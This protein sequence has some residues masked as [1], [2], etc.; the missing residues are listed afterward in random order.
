MT[1]P[2]TPPLGVR[3]TVYRTLK[4]SLTSACP[5]AYNNADNCRTAWSG[6]EIVNWRLV[7]PI[8]LLLC[9]GLSG[10]CVTSPLTARRTK[11]MSEHLLFNPEWTGLSLNEV[12]R[13]D[14]P[15][16]PAFANGGEQVEYRETIIDRQGDFGVSR[17]RLYRRF[18]SVRQGHRER[19]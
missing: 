1:K 10:C 18:D 17:D 5:V 13:G 19:P 8:A 9:V 3:I 16:T 4:L 12:P 7:V 14:W 11:V 15:S 6:R 2:P